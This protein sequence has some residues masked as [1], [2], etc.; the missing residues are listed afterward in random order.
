MALPNRLLRPGVFN[1]FVMVD[2][3]G[4]D[5]M[6]DIR[7]EPELNTLELPQLPKINGTRNATSNRRMLTFFI[8]ITFNWVKILITGPIVQAT[9][10]DLR[11]QRQSFRG[12]ILYIL[13]VSAG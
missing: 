11:N 2:K 8:K 10:S 1:R 6:A 13:L 7:E 3:L 9:F 4:F 12:L 5:A